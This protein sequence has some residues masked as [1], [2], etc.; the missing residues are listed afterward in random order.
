MPNLELAFVAIAGGVG[1]WVACALLVLAVRT[2]L[3]RAARL[4]EHR[5]VPSPLP[6]GAVAYRPRRGYIENKRRF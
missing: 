1:I 3:N 5:L 4:A 2:R 6:V